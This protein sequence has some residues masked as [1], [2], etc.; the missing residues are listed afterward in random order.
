MREL[1]AKEIKTVTGKSRLLVSA[2]EPLMNVLGYLAE[3]VKVNE[4]VVR[5]VADYRSDDD[6]RFVLHQ[7]EL[8]GLPGI[9]LDSFDD[10][11]PVWLRVER[12]QKIE[13]PTV[14]SD[15]GVWIEV[16]ADP[17]RPPS[18]HESVMVTVDGAE[19]DRLLEA[20]QARA[21]DLEPAINPDRRH[22]NI[23]NVRLRLADYPGLAS[24]LDTY[25]TGPWAKWAHAE[26]LRRSTMAIH[27]RMLDVLPVGDPTD[28][29][30]EMVWGL[31]VSRWRRDGNDIVLPVLERSVAIE[32]GDNGE[33]RIRPRMAGAI[34]DLRGF[35]TGQASTSAAAVESS[36]RIL[37]AIEREGE[38]SPFVPDSF[39]PILRTVSSQLDP[40]G[41]YLGSDHDW[42]KPGDASPGAADHLAVSNRWVIFARPRTKSLLLRDIERFREAIERIARADGEIPMLARVL[43]FGTSDEASTG[44][45]QALSGVIGRP[46]DIEPVAEQA[47]AESGDVFFPLP[48]SM[49]LTDVVRRLQTSDGL[50]VRAAPGSAKSNAIVNIV[51][52]HLALGQRVLVVCRGKAALRELH[53]KFP[54]AI[55]D[56]TI[57]LTGGDRQELAQVEAVVRRLQSIIETIKP[58]D[59]VDLIN[60]L[61][62]D[63][64]AT[65]RLV[66]DL[67]EEASNIARN[68]PGF[69]EMPFDLARKL[70]VEADAHAWF[71]DR[72]L[73]LLIDAGISLAAVDAARAARIRLGADLC[74]I[75]DDLPALALLPEPE[76]IAHMHH[77]LAQDVEARQSATEPKEKS[78]ARRAVT[79]LDLEGA[80]RFADDLE[81]LAAAHLTVVDEPWLGPSS[82][83]RKHDDGTRAESAA[84]VEFARDATSQLSRRAAFLLRP[85]DVP[86]DALTDQAVFDL[87]GRLSAGEKV[88]S[89]FASRE[90]RLKPVVAAITIAG[91]AA[92]GRGD[93]QHV[94]DYL[95]WRRDIQALNARWKALAVELGVPTPSA[96]Y[97][98][99]IHGFERT[100]KSINVAI[101]TAAVAERNVIAVAGSKLLISRG[102]IDALLAD[103]SELQK[104]A[105]AVRA[106]LTEREASRL[107]LTRLQEMFAGEGVLPAAVRDEVLARIGQG[108]ADLVSGNWARLRRQIVQLHD[109]REDFDRVDA[110]C[111]ALTEAGAPIFAR[112]VRTEV[113]QPA[114]GDHVFDADWAGAWNWA[115]LTRQLKELGQDQHLRQYTERREQLEKTLRGQF[116]AVVA[117]RADFA[118]ARSLSSTFRRALT[119]FMIAVRKIASAADGLAAHH[120]RR[121]AREALDGCCE[122]IPCWIMPS[123]RVA[124]RLPAKLGAFDLVV[125]DEASGADVCELATLLRGRKILVIDDDRQVEP[126]SLRSNNP[127]METLGDTFLRALPRTIRPFVLPGSSLYDLAKV[128]FPGNHIHLREDVLAYR[129]LIGPTPRSEAPWPLVAAGTGDD[130][131]S[132]GVANDE[133]REV[134]DPW[135]APRTSARSAAEIMAE[136]ISKV[137][138][139][140]PGNNRLERPDAVLV[141]VVRRPAPWD[142]E[143]Q[144]DTPPIEDSQIARGD[145]PVSERS[146]DTDIRFAALPPLRVD[147]QTG[148]VGEDH[149]REPRFDE[150]GAPPWLVRTRPE[151]NAARPDTGSAGETPAK[152]EKR[153]GGPELNVVAQPRRAESRW[154]GRGRSVAIAAV[155]LIMLAPAVA[156]SLSGLGMNSRLAASLASISDLIPRKF[157]LPSFAKGP[158]LLA[159]GD[160]QDLAQKDLAQKDPAQKNLTSVQPK[161]VATTRIDPPTVGESPSLA[162]VI[163][164][165]PSLASVM[166]PVAPRAVLYEEDPTDSKG[167]RYAGGVTWRTENVSPASGMPPELVVKA[168]MNVTDAKTAVS[169]TFRRNTDRKMPASHLVEIKFDRPR[170]TPSGEISKLHGLLMKQEGKI[171]GAPLEGEA[172]KVTSG[173]FMIALA[174]GPQQLQRNLKLLKDYPG[175]EV[176]VDYSNG[177]K[178]ILLFDKGPS[179]EQ[180]FKEA[181]AAWGQ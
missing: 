84:L 28:R 117:A 135:Q 142:D 78:L 76:A 33:I 120:H 64:I 36:R 115:A 128:M 69:A 85:V 111:K 157:S 168:D 15:L 77:D 14:D 125:I 53:D 154:A 79:V 75:D 86:P 7:H 164:P 100:V 54:S 137:V 114:S 99:M 21:T 160:E 140:L 87:V 132:G 124:E 152:G 5:C 129:D 92:D 161:N 144:I 37:E 180:A 30:D 112:R 73:A 166:A 51:C 35:Q 103:V 126:P 108:D 151:D 72:P 134:D 101:V 148:E 70:V 10:D 163:A 3:V 25:V 29:S 1:R 16:S 131:L 83:L 146:P 19:K 31:G 113:A 8:D 167:K 45:R 159:Q 149:P 94:R 60:K 175:F 97:P 130:A 6:A 71:E 27:A 67:M 40:E 138:A 104:L 119:I 58:R 98:Q 90:K 34:S 17:D 22:Y 176:V 133:F 24:R 102:D 96:D 4:P 158:D 171:H 174:S 116:E 172:A 170:D 74:H 61:E 91:M 42:S 65:R 46:I 110:V 93:W 66:S 11:G 38:V 43:A 109:R 143:V 107:E 177:R 41:I 57:G 156:Y 150:A 136:E 26:K 123:W 55:R 23:F 12:L 47:N 82:P 9:K 127:Q 88:F 155:F 50:V 145:W 2:V 49:D 95:T 178:A 118:A 80:G 13:P 153:T 56:L 52:H 48:S 169:M 62:S 121:M 179:G 141:P 32:V 105:A 181:F 147:K 39:E 59:H 162:S 89:A 106:A 81:A 18:I 165:S 20:K 63:V 122:G 173:Y 68:T 44:M 139:R